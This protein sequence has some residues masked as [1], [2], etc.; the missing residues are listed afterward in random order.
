MEEPEVL[1][2]VDCL[3]HNIR[4]LIDNAKGCSIFPVL[5]ANAYGHG[6]ELIAKT[7]EKSFTDEQVPFF[8]LARLSEA[9]ALRK[10]G[11]RR[12]FLILNYFSREDLLAGTEF[13]DHT[14]LVI[15]DL[16]DLKF[17]CSMTAVESK[18]VAGIHLNFN[19]GMNRL[20]FSWDLSSSEF[21]RL[22]DH[23]K[24][25]HERKIAVRGLMTHLAR[26][27]ERSSHYSELQLERFSKIYQRLKT[28][29]DESVHGK[30]PHWVHIENSGGLG[31][32]VARKTPWINGARPGLHLW[33]VE[34]QKDAFKH[35]K[36]MPVMTVRAPVRQ[37]FWVEKGEPIGYGGTFVCQRKT[38]VATVSLGYADG[39]NR[40]FSSKSGVG[41]S[42]AHDSVGF[43]VEGEVAKIVGRVSMDL[44]TIDLTDHPKVA[45]WQKMMNQSERPLIWAYW[46][47]ERQGVER[48][49]SALGTIPYEVLCSV[50]HRVARREK[51]AGEA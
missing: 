19:T 10:S 6:L 43:V 33:G 1:I 46:I 18:K 7:F 37:L 15:N 22:F 29:W 42:A 27:E 47:S 49:A 34:A 17:L 4:Q 40:S 35:L 31:R 48:I 41:S 39:V 25:L 38:L 36:L 9:R 8:C 51:K 2:D 45:Q 13:P 44:T 26:G 12:S 23:L 11:V 50:A 24:T 21:S 14:D 16:A 32:S 30:F 5:K 3:K 28:D 20:G